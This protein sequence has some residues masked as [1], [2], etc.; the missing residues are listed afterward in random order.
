M[1]KSPE[2]DVIFIYGNV[3]LVL[4]DCNFYKV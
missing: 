1:E 4:H 2:I 3:I